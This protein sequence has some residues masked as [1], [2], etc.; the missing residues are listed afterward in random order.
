MWKVCRWTLIKIVTPLAPFNIFIGWNT[1]LRKMKQQMLWCSVFQSFV[2]LNSIYSFVSGACH[3]SHHSS[4]CRTRHG[5]SS[6]KKYRICSG[7][8]NH[9]FPTKSPLRATNQFAALWVTSLGAP[10]GGLLSFLSFFT[11]E[12]QI[13]PDVLKW[14]LTLD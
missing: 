1:L 12:I 14:N 4:R 8:D 3:S 10:N 13:G 7:D 5:N 6:A 2:M 9:V 11:A